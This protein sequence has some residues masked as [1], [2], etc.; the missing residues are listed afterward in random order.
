MPAPGIVELV[1]IALGVV[2]PVV[3]IVA[4]GRLILAPFRRDDPAVQILKDRFASGEIDEAE[5]LRLRSVLQRG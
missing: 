1:V 3:L 5:Y 2:I 4:I